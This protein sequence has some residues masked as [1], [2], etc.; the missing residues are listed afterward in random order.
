MIF[1]KAT[2]NDIGA[3]GALYDTVCEHLETHVNWPGWKKGVYPTRADAEK[4]VREGTLYMLRDGGE[5]IGA[6][7]LSHEPEAGYAG[8]CWGTPDEYDKI[9]MIYALAV[10][11]DRMRTGVAGRMMEEAEKI[12]RE[13]GCVAMRLDA[14]TGN[15][16]AEKLYTRCGFR[17]VVTKSLGYECYGLPRF[18][19]FEKIL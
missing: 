5:I 12:A 10:R 4:G 6:V 16:P 15:L 14:V 3:V 2:R 1:K 7:K 8:V 19:L 17:C 13:Q 18:D 11:P 9:L